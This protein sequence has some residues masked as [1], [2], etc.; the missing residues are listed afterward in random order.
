VSRGRYFFEFLRIFG[1][2]P[3]RDD[4]GAAH[5]LILGAHSSIGRALVREMSERRQAFLAAN[6]CGVL[7]FERQE[8][9]DVLGYVSISGCIVADP[10]DCGVV[11][12]K[13]LAKWAAGRGIPVTIAA[14]PH[15]RERIAGVRTVSIPYFVDPEF[16][17]DRW[18]L[19]YRIAAECEKA[20]R[21]V[22]D[23]APDELVRSITADKI[24]ADLLDGAEVEKTAETASVESIAVAVEELGCTVE[25]VD[26]RGATPTPSVEI[27]AFVRDVF[28]R[29][30]PTTETYLSMV[31][32]G[33][34]DGFSKGFEHRAQIFLD[35]LANSSETVPL[36]NWEL[37]F[38]DYATPSEVKPLAATFRIPPR[39]KSRMRF[40]NVPVSAHVQFSRM[41]NSSVSFLE[42]V[43]KNV[44]IR[45]S[46]GRFILTT[47]P[48]N[49]FGAEF[50]RQVEREEFNE[51]VLYRA[52]RWSAN[53]GTESRFSAD[54]LRM[55]LDNEDSLAD[56]SLSS[57]CP[58]SL[59]RTSW[60]TAVDALV[61][62]AW[63][64]GAGDF[65][66]MSRRM[67]FAVHGFNEYPGNANVDALFL[68]KL[69]VIVPGYVRH[70]I[71]TPIIHQYHP[72]QNIFRPSVREHEALMKDYACHAECPRLGR[73]E[74]SDS[75]GF[76]DQQFNETYL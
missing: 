73:Y 19:L 7:D 47:N 58:R 63:P 57:R 6:G 48:D 41:T 28:G 23:V 2:D 69:M 43:A 65:L 53:E 54:E 62:N 27:P 67:W 9:R 59:E 29:T 64:C 38:V 20:N 42:Y 16:P 24:A 46:K 75:W 70:I 40:V 1:V 15:F 71:R 76:G 31:V 18:N 8:L 25:F 33:R 5:L 72:R 34:H 39:L 10:D 12:L 26:G 44:G 22:V 45:R 30:L 66:L 35:S 49:I 51:L 61:D 74:D 3:H 55:A 60:Q 21:S 32:V 37:I 36:A 56:L 13:S 52:N 17:N 50:F 68:G 11:F 4:L 14:L